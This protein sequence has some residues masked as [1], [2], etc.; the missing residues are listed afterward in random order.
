MRTPNQKM[1]TYPKDEKEIRKEEL[2]G[3]LGI[4]S[5]FNHEH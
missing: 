5:R 2:D 3:Q 1:W 4:G